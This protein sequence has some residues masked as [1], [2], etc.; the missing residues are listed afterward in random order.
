MKKRE[1]EGVSETNASEGTNRH[2]T[3]NEIRRGIWGTIRVLVLLSVIPFPFPLDPIVLLGT[4]LPRERAETQGFSRDWW[5]EAYPS[6]APPKRMFL[7]SV[8]KLRYLNAKRK[9][10]TP[11]LQ[12]KNKILRRNLVSAEANSAWQEKISKSKGWRNVWIGVP[13]HG[14]S[15]YFLRNCKKY[16]NK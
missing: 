6:M 13:Q 9:R 7:K 11:R 12:E 2:L 3:E 14:V 1:E 8:C 15:L 4:L 16:R 5:E 10:S